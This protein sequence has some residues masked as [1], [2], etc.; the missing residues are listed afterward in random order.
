M[1]SKGRMSH[2]DETFV[3][4]AGC[5][6]KAGRLLTFLSYNNTLN[7]RVSQKYVK[8]F[9]SLKSLLGD[10]DMSINTNTSDINLY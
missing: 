5:N 2:C 6:E 3:Y 1:Q 7:N 9:V 8:V 4:E 10:S